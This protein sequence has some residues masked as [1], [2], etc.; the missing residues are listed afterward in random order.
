MPRWQREAARACAWWPVAG[1][2]TLLILALA[3]SAMASAFRPTPKQ[4]EADLMLAGPQRHN[5]LVGGSRSGKTFQL[6]KA[7]AVRAMRAP[8]SPAWCPARLPGP[9]VGGW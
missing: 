3:G 5:M 9:S 7:S 6:V 2:G 4:L 8:E 1:A